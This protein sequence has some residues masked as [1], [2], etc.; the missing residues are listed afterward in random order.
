MATFV[1]SR[2]FFLSYLHIA[3]HLIL[4]PILWSEYTYYIHRPDGE[5]KLQRGYAIG[6]S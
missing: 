3:T 1:M 5:T 4:T 6:P 2:Y